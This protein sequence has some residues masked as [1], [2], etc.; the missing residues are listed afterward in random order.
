MTS[1]TSSHV[2]GDA[3][4]R[5]G[6]RTAVGEGHSSR[7]HRWSVRTRLSSSG[8]AAVER[9]HAGL[10]VRDRH[11]APAPRPARRRASS[12]CRRRRGPRRAAPAPAA[13]PSA[14][15][16]RAVCSVFVPPRMPSSRSGRGIPSSCDEDRRQ[17]VVVVL[18]G[19]DEQLLV[20]RSRSRRETAAALTNC[21]RLPMTVTTL[22]PPRRAP[23]RCARE[24]RAPAC[25]VSG[26]GASGSVAAVDRA[27]RHGPRASSRPGTP[28]HAPAARRA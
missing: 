15:S 22:K 11:A 20:R 2:A 26:P 19:V 21:G 4:A 23:P 1:P 13:A 3:L 27:D 10:D 5:A 25:R 8:I 16:M 6:C 9:A 24:S 14:A 18:A 12:S 7:S 17:L 28:R